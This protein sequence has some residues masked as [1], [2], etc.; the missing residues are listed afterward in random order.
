LSPLIDF[1]F[2]SYLT[3]TFLT[4][5]SYAVNPQDRAEALRFY[6][7]YYLANTSVPIGWTGSLAGCNPGVTSAAFRAAVLQRI[8]YFRGMAGV[9]PV[10]LNG[11]SN[12]LAQAAALMMSVNRSLDHTPPTTWLCYS[13]DGADGAGSGNLALGAMGWDAIALYMQDPGS[14]NTAL[15]HRRW[16]LYPQTQEMGTGDIPSSAGY[17]PANAL[18]VFDEHMWEPRPITRDSFVA[19]PPPGYVPRPVVYPRWSFSYPSANF[20]S[21]SVTMTLGGAN[22]PLTVFPVVNGYGENT[23]AWEISGLSGSGDQSYQVR[24]VNVVIGGQSRS[25]N[26]TVTVFTP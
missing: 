4:D 12:R 10:A 22:V 5:D 23:L 14:G 9:P 16:I 18:V 25:F 6:Q 13:K 24:I 11:D 7:D 21:A 3:V 2:E 17:P 15:G 8:N 26:Y 20:A 1:E 19:W